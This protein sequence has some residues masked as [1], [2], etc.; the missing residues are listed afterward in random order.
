MTVTASNNI[1]Q[2]NA[3][4]R[5]YAAL[6]RRD[7]ADSLVK[8]G[9]DFPKFLS[10]EL[11]RFTPAKGQVRSE[12][13]AALKAGGGVKVRPAAIE[14]AR[15][16]T[17]ATRS[18]V[19]TRKGERFRQVSKGG[20]VKKGAKT[21]W[22]LAVQRELNIRES[23]RGYVP[24]SAKFAG[25]KGRLRA[26]QYGNTQQ[27]TVDRASRGISRAVFSNSRNDTALT[28]SWGNGNNATNGIAR[29]L[30]K[31]GQQGAIAAALNKVRADMLEYIRDKRS[32]DN[33]RFK[34]N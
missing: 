15:K 7:A 9:G 28:M 14:Y 29:A 23:G 2:F 1:D 20:E 10:D 8:K 25:L 30:Q 31:A 11:R 17:A 13:R 27:V 5:E 3:T 34:G 32:G 18:N 12:R 16:N 4:L 22:A 19:A 6:R 33:K 24:Y 26:E 21:F